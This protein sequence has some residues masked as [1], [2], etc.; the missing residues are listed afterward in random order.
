ML[1]DTGGPVK[2][3]MRIHRYLS[4]LVAPAMVFFAVS[5]AWQAFRLQDSRKDGS[6]TAPVALQQL[7]NVHKAERLSGPAA[8]WFRVGQLS[9]ATAFVLTAVLGVVM[10]LRIARPVWTVWA[11]L[12]CGAVLPVLLAL[13]VRK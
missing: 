6:Y 4:C 1:R 3:L 11:C 13:A 8:P 9:L 7:S 12:A 5:G 2:Q 10:A